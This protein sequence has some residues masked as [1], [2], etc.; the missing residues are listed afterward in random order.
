MFIILKTLHSQW[1]VGEGDK[2]IVLGESDSLW[3]YI[4]VIT[5]WNK[6]ITKTTRINDASST[7]NIDQIKR[8]K[9]D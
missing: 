7:D 9:F 3:R 2:I 5:H 6:R 1:A 8:F 4:S